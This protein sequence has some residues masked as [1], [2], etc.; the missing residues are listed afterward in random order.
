MYSTAVCGRKGS[1]RMINTHVAVST[2]FMEN[3][4][5]VHAKG[6]S[7]YSRKTCTRA[8]AKIIP[9]QKGMESNVKVEGKNF[10]KRCDRWTLN[11]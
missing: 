7:F 6:P 1:T 10:L 2:E 5:Q 9:V 11:P 3:S 8:V 4:S